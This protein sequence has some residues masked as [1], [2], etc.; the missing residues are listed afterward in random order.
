MNIGVKLATVCVIGM[1]FVTGCGQNN[2]SQLWS[3]KPKQISESFKT[4]LIELLGLCGE[5]TAQTGAGVNQRD[6]SQILAKA[7]AKSEIVFAMWPNS[8]LPAEKKELQQAIYGWDLALQLW[9]EDD[10]SVEQDSSLGQEI[11]SYGV[12]AYSRKY[13]FK[14]GVSEILTKAS[15]HYDEAKIRLLNAVSQ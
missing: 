3:S 10:Y 12:I 8:F 5:I 14:Q 15:E 9:N 6:F 11:K 1:M 4:S 7:K 2:V 13:S